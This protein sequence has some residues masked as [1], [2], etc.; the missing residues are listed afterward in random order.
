[1]AIIGRAFF[2]PVTAK[3]NQAESIDRRPVVRHRNQPR[4]RQFHGLLGL[5]VGQRWKSPRRRKWNRPWSIRRWRFTRS[6]PAGARL[7]WLPGFRRSIRGCIYC[8]MATSFARENNG[9]H[10]VYALHQTWTL[11]YATTV[12]TRNRKGGAS[13]LLQ[14]S[15]ATGYIP[16]VMIIGGD[17]PNATATA[18][19]IDLSAT[20]PAWR[21]VAPMS[22]PRTRLNAVILPT[23]KILALGGSALDE[24]PTRAS[25]AADL[26]DPA[27]ETWS[28]AGAGDFIR[29]FI[30]LARCSCQTAPWRWSGAIRRRERTS[31]T[32]SAIRRP[33]FLRGRSVW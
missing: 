16:K 20:T 9:L 10:Y 6:A 7:I 17:T 15:P 1:M 5:G 21:S 24:D 8:R 2:D 31:N 14:L 26:F 22:L 33:T 19:I 4:R 3:F 18:E 23:G 27:T 11:N 25:L 12:Y 30:T 28:S 29:D 13:V 32:S